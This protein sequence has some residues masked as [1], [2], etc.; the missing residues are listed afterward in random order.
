M[1]NKS[2][3]LHVLPVVKNLFIFEYQLKNLSFVEDFKKK[4]NQEVNSHD[5]NNFKTNVKGKMT[6]WDFFNKDKNFHL[7]LEESCS[8]LK[9]I[10]SVDMKIESSWGNIL[11]DNDEVLEHDHVARTIALSGILYLTEDGPGTYFKL[12]NK[13]IDEKIGKIVFFSSELRHSVPKIKIEKDRYTV[14]FN[15]I[16]VIS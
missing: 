14:A 6:R 13:S 12:L 15:L 1:D 2:Y 10:N 9:I 3:S 11:S 8:F 5:N 7:C 16:P 4:I